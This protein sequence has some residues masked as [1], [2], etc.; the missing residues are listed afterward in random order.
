MDRGRR[1]EPYSNATIWTR[2]I[3]RNLAGHLSRVSKAHSCVDTRSPKSTRLPQFHHSYAQKRCPTSPVKTRQPL[4]LISRN[5][6]PNAEQ[7][8]DFRRLGGGS[9]REEIEGASLPNANS[10]CDPMQQYNP[11][12]GVGDSRLGEAQQQLQRRRSNA[13]GE[14]NQEISDRPVRIPAVK[15]PLKQ[16]FGTGSSSDMTTYSS[17]LHQKHH[18]AQDYYKRQEQRKIWL[19]NQ[20][21][22]RICAK[23]SAPG[24]SNQLIDSPA[25]THQASAENESHVELQGMGERWQVDPRVSEEPRKAAFGF[26]TRAAPGAGLAASSLASETSQS[27]APVSLE[28]Y[29][30]TRQE[31][32]LDMFPNKG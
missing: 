24:V 21:Q 23:D 27:S 11:K 19:E 32:R 6:N 2:E 18:V 31:P 5:P 13:G 7:E 8:L 1:A 28:E 4:V 15:P 20:V 22:R 30:S 9:A 16:N 25:G 26:A 29:S 14:P 17:P 12:Q 10:E 3:A